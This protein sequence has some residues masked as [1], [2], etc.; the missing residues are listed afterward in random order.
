M[1]RTKDYGGIIVAHL[2]L[3][4]IA[5]A[6][7]IVNRVNIFYW[8]RQ[9]HIEKQMI[10]G[11]PLNIEGVTYFLIFN[12][13][14]LLTYVCFLRAAF[15][16]PGRIPEG[17]VAP[18]KSEHSKMQTCAE[19]TGKETWKPVRAH[20]CVECG[21]CVFKMDHHCPWINNCVGHK[22]TKFFM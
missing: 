13:L 12:G 18:F 6:Q 19:C 8:H 21:I 3:A 14:C 9:R 4:L 10:W 16:D 7:Y 20:H 2:S 22:N 17:T 15:A 11:I 5:F 1:Y